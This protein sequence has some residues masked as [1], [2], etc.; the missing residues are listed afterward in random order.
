GTRELRGIFSYLLIYKILQALEAVEH[1][2][3]Q[4]FSSKLI[5]K[6]DSIGHFYLAKSFFLLNNL[7]NAREQL[8]LF[9]VTNPHHADGVYLLAEVEKQLQN[10]TIAWQYL[11]DLLAYS[12]R[13]KTW[14]HL[15]NLVDSVED[16]DGFYTLFSKYVPTVLKE[17]LPF[18]LVCHLSNAAIRSGN[19]GFALELW[20]QQYQLSQ[21]SSIKKILSTSTK[22]T[23]KKAETALSTLKHCLNK[24]NIP[25]FLISGT[26]LGCIREGKLLSH[27]KDID[28]GVWEIYTVQELDQIIRKSG[29]FY[30]LPIYSKNIL[31]VRHTN[32]ITIDIFIH[33]REEHGYWHGGGKSK[34]HNSP[35]TLKPC[36]FLGQQYL[37]PE[38][39]DLY[40]T[41]NY[42]DWRIP[43]IDFD[44]A[45]DT[46]NMEIISQ[47]DFLIYLYKKITFALHTGKKPSERYLNIL[48]EHDANLD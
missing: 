25:F 2:K 30:I 7:E 48:R 33:Y 15:S 24:N 27:D 10:K 17:A 23:D 18:D 20:K 36:Y 26:L 19:T 13:R 45:L 35:F 4:L 43:K 9:L 37:V 41:E 14:Q 47:D 11:E 32:G 22:Y 21:H 28:I 40:L 8:I 5:K 6:K 1:Q 44:S 12:K 29:C 39:Y 3:I 46:P 38:D 16:F 34:W 42:G 31:V